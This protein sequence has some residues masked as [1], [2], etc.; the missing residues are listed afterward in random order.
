M[1]PS[2]P[3]LEESPRQ[4]AL[5]HPGISERS[6]HLFS[7]PY[8]LLTSKRKD[9]GC[10]GRG[11]R[12]LCLGFFT[13][14]P[15]PMALRP[16]PYASGRR[17]SRSFSRKEFWVGAESCHTH[18]WMRSSTYLFSAATLGKRLPGGKSLGLGTWGGVSPSAPH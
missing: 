14:E 16:F 4:L 7:E 8:W 9:I 15:F 13:P 3:F 18:T 2:Q 11:R 5:V 1:S 17:F 10:T 6:P 12:T